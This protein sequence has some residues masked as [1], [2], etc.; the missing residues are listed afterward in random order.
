MALTS[1]NATAIAASILGTRLKHRLSRQWVRSIAI[2]GVRCS[3]YN[4]GFP[5]RDHPQ[6]HRRLTRLDS[7]NFY[8]SNS[9]PAGAKHISCREFKAAKQVFVIWA[10][11]Q[12]FW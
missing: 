10:K 3:S 9:L 6:R 8:V 4:T 11:N 2:V 12:E 7:C 1:A 5:C